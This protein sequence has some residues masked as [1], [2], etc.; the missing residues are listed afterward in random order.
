MRNFVTNAVITNNLI[1]DCGIYDFQYQFDGKIGE[2]IYIG[3]S[4]NQ[5]WCTC[6]CWLG[7]DST[8]GQRFLPGLSQHGCSCTCLFQRCCC[9]G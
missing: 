4:S 5:V 7:C 9:C 2:A 6:R 8:A 3:T 1:E